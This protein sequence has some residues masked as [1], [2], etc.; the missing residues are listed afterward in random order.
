MTQGILGLRGQGMD[1]RKNASRVTLLRRDWL[2]G[3]EDVSPVAQSY[4]V[5][6]PPGA[7]YCVARLVAGGGGRDASISTSTG[8]GGD[9][10][11]K[12]IRVPGQTPLAVSVS[13]AANLDGSD[14]QDTTVSLGGVVVCRAGGGE[15]GGASPGAAGPRAQ[16]LGDVIRGG[17]AGTSTTGG[18]SGSD[19]D[20]PDTLWLGGFTKTSPATAPASDGTE[21]PVLPVYGSGG[22][23]GS[24]DG[25][26][27]GDGRQGSPGVAVLEFYNLKPY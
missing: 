19:I 26:F 12:L 6:P 4:T 14:G 9:Y 7:L 15:G 13:N 11:R 23:P 18:A 25:P 16:S 20:D 24:S 5:T 10:A 17:E 3:I 1:G 27:V 22:A 21:P 2:Y 8:A